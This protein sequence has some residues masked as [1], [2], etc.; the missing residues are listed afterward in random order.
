MHYF[1]NIN[2]VSKNLTKINQMIWMI[3]SPGRGGIQQH[4]PYNHPRIRPISTISFWWTTLCQWWMVPLHLV[5]FENL[6]ILVRSFIVLHFLCLYFPVVMR[7]SLSFDPVKSFTLLFVVL[8]LVS[9]TGM[10][11]G[12]T[13]NGLASDISH[14]VSKGA[15]CVLTKPF[16]LDE[17]HT[18]ILKFAAAL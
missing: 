18:Q 14:F 7:C 11:I 13:G 6:V 12:V 8:F 15:S 1:P 9:F 10:I 17:F 16:N 5:Q 3:P 4:Q 2:D